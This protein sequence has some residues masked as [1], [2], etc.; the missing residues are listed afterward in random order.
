MEPVLKEEEVAETAGPFAMM[1]IVVGKMDR[2]INRMDYTLQTPKQLR[3][4][5]MAGDQ[6]KEGSV[7]QKHDVSLDR[8]ITE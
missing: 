3:R 6:K 4:S 7:R 1:K 8:L 2:T 5:E